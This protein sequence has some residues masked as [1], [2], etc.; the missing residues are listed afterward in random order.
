MSKNNVVYTLLSFVILSVIL[1]GCSNQE[2]LE[3]KIKLHIEV[4]EDIIPYSYFIASIDSI[5]IINDLESYYSTIEDICIADSSLFILDASS[6]LV[7]VN[8]TS[9]K[10]K[11]K[12]NIKGHSNSESISAKAITCTEEHVYILDMNGK[13]ILTFDS[14]L[15]YLEHIPIP[16]SSLDFAVIPNGFLLLNMNCKEDTDMVVSIDKKGK[17]LN[18]F[19]SNKGIPEL[20]LSQ[21]IFSE[22]KDGITIV[23]PLQNKTFTYDNKTNNVSCLIRYE[24]SSGSN[25]KIKNKKEISFPDA[26]TISF[27][28]ERY[29]VTSY[30]ANQIGGTCVY[31]KKNKTTR[32][33]LIKTETLY[34]F[35]PIVLKDNIL[36]GVYERNSSTEENNRYIIVKYELKK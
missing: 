29:I 9:G 12:I 36:Y 21:R 18:K 8:L 35:M 6:N 32:S 34:P 25:E 31:D 26:T 13:K 24:L 19:I 11:K 7:S 22:T 20:I 4:S 5:P 33:G 15:D 3:E 27:D 16:V 28:S 30:L 1:G 17:I 14:N 2:S 10:V 23:P